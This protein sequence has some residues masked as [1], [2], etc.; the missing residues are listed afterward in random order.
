MLTRGNKQLLGRIT[1]VGGDPW[2][3]LAPPSLADLIPCNSG[4]SSIEYSTVW[5]EELS[6]DLIPEESPADDTFFEV[7]GGEIRPVAV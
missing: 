3:M 5:K 4:D 6:G 2:E 1:S 7:V